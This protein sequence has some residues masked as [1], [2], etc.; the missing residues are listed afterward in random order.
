MTYGRAYS[1]FV[2]P[3]LQ[4]ELSV[5]AR[6]TVWRTPDGTWTVTTAKELVVLDPRLAPVA[7]F[8]LPGDW[9]GTHA[10][11]P[12]AGSAALSLTDRVA[13]VD[14]TGH[15]RWEIP[16]TPWT[17]GAS[18]SAW[19]T[20]D[21]LVWAVVPGPDGAGSPDHWWVLDA[22]TGRLLHDTALDGSSAGSDP[23][24]HRGGVLLGVSP[25]GHDDGHRIYVGRHDGAGVT[26]QPLPGS[27]RVL[28][29]VHRSGDRYLTTDRHHEDVAV[30]SL[31][32]GTALV[33]RPAEEVF[34]TGDFIDFHAAFVTDDRVVVRSVLEQ[35][36]LVLDATRLEVISPVDYPDG[37]AR[38]AVLPAGDGSWVT[39]DW[40]DGRVQLW[41]LRDRL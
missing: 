8:P 10:V 25:G 40:L 3:T 18:G 24:G 34:G 1:A 6:S 5:E 39:T 32:D 36:H 15:T 33:T 26:V 30:H 20:P 35:E 11:A 27:D 21:G 28:A 22:A 2:Q 14:V 38:D 16:H 17:S 13:V 31:A 23:I 9:P 19:I 4:A 7:R 41:T 37:A 12:D 29:D